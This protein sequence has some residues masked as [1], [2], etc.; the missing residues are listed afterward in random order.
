MGTAEALQ[1]KQDDGDEGQQDPKSLQPIDPL[2]QND[3]GQHD[4]GGRVER[5]QHRGNIEPSRLGG[6]DIKTV[7]GDIHDA[8][9]ET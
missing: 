2:F 9:E 5:A 1:G 8:I 7:P 3:P 6:E 4:S